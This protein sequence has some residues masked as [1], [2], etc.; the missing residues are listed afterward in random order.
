M[1]IT[2]KMAA[3][4]N[5]WFSFLQYP[6]ALTEMI[7]NIF[8]IYV[9]FKSARADMNGLEY[10]FASRAHKNEPQLQK[11]GCMA[12][13]SWTFTIQ[14]DSNWKLA[15][16]LTILTCQQVSNS[17]SPVLP[18]V[19]TPTLQNSSNSHYLTTVGMKQLID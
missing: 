18:L 19:N 3:E 9:D 11:T 14:P 2:N 1:F 12:R 7:K 5:V 16:F 8:Q 4:P 6:A 15:Y 10:S 17:C 13:W